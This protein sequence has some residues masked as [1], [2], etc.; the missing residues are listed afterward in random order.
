MRQSQDSKCFNLV[1]LSFIHYIYVLYLA[2]W[3]VFLSLP[4]SERQQEKFAMSLKKLELFFKSLP[5]TCETV[6]RLTKDSWESL[7]RFQENLE[8]TKQML[9]E[10]VLSCYSFLPPT[11][12]MSGIHFYG[13]RSDSINLIISRERCF[14]PN[15]K[16]N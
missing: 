6:L 4:F 13:I 5:S 12:C 7:Q 10:W 15:E 14:E 11:W 2:L 3:F 16:K 8:A 9:L 1:I